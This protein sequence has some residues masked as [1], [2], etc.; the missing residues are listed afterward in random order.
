MYVTSIQPAE[1]QSKVLCKKC[2][3]SVITCLAD[4]YDSKQTNDLTHMVTLCGHSG[5][6]S[7]A[8]NDICRYHSRGIV[9]GVDFI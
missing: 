4:K 7:E 2:F 1:K 8:Q 9:P 3:L 6:S 5:V